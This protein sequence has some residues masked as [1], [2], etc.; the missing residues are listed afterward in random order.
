MG[1]LHFTKGGRMS[2]TRSECPSLR[3]LPV[4]PVLVLVLAI[5][6]PAWLHAAEADGPPS[7]GA[8]GMCGA[9]GTFELKPDDWTGTDTWWEDTDGI[10]P[11]IAG[12]H[13]ELSSEHGEPKPKGRRFGEFC[14]DENGK[15]LLVE[16]NPAADV[17]HSHTKDIG[18]P[19]KF[20]CKMWCE[21]KGYARG[22]C[23]VVASDDRRCEGLK[24]AK[25]ACSN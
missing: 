5:C 20:D 1:A 19:D 10:R 6:T 2:A 23:E 21:G 12:C 25:C 8:L 3:R 9:M 7:E 13:L 14:R 11:D 22:V 15:K 4:L 16:T 24:S 17:G 18:H